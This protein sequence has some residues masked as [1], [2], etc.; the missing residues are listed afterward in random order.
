MNWS[1]ER[2]GSASV[3]ISEFEPKREEK[4][5]FRVE[6]PGFAHDSFCCKRANEAE[7]EGANRN[8]AVIHHQSKENVGRQ[9]LV[10]K[11]NLV[12]EQLQNVFKNQPGSIE[13]EAHSIGTLLVLAAANKLSDEDFKRIDKIVLVAPIPFG[14][15]ARYAT[16]LSFNARVGIDGFLNSGIGLVDP[17]KGNVVSDGSANRLFGDGCQKARRVADSTGTFLE[18]VAGNYDDELEKLLER[19]HKMHIKD[20][21]RRLSIIG[22]NQDNCHKKEWVEEVAFSHGLGSCLQMIDGGHCGWSEDE[23]GRV[24]QVE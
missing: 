20:F 12:S 5:V 13:L 23:N 7:K 11:I 2:E 16:S 4:R 10:E 9:S 17:N 19:A 3:H 18:L 8:T 24:T 15:K 6:V 14:N 1:H 21:Y 22:F